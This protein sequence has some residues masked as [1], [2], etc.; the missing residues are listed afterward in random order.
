MRKYKKN[1]YKDI[2]KLHQIYFSNLRRGVQV[3]AS[4]QQV[5]DSFKPYVY[6]SDDNKFWKE[7]TKN[8]K[9]RI[10]GKMAKERKFSLLKRH[11]KS[12]ETISKIQIDWVMDTAKE[13]SKI[14]KNVSIKKLIYHQSIVIF[15]S[16]FESFLKDVFVLLIDGDDEIRKKVLLSN[17]KISLIQMDAINKR[18]LSLGEVI[19]RNYNF[20]NL[21]SI[22]EAYKFL[23]N[24][25]LKDGIIKGLGKKKWDLLIDSIEK[26]H[27]ILHALLYDK[28]LDFDKV[29]LIYSS[30]ESV[31]FI[32][33]LII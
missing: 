21:N 24:I 27:L 15:V 9:K 5:S 11:K 17:K 19:S 20:Q 26:R 8:M 25:D 14:N 1:F 2:T 31:G 10:M 16:A 23:L 3:S 6:L 29:K 18:N 30:F 28:N 12:Y 7:Y 22:F 13:T 4:A 32:I 33:P